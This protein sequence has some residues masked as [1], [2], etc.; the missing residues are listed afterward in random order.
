M[1]MHMRTTL[2]IDDDLLREAQT[3]TGIREKTATVRA[4]LEALIARESARRLAAPGRS[5]RRHPAGGGRGA[6]AA[7]P[8]DPPPQGRKTDLMLVDTSVWVDLF[9]R[10][11]SALAELLDRGQV[12]SHPFVTGE[13]SC[14]NLRIR[15]EILSLLAA[16][17][18]AVLAG[19]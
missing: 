12:R 8:P 19:H 2:N 18:L 15:K 10:G 6:G 11:N 1:L 4:A 17:P 14:G 3:L 13:L 9:R 16:L 7:A 5:A